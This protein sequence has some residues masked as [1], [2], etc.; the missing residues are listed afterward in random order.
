M[1]KGKNVDEIVKILLE[2]GFIRIPGGEVVE[3]LKALRDQEVCIGRVEVLEESGA[4][5]LYN[6]ISI[7]PSSAGAPSIASFIFWEDAALKHELLQ[8]YEYYLGHL[9][10]IPNLLDYEVELWAI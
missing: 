6:P 1:T 3:L 2:N 5:L 4:V 9:K 7:S 8:S 10:D